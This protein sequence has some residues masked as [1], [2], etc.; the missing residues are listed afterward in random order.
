MTRRLHNFFAMVLMCFALSACSVPK[1][2]ET[3]IQIIDNHSLKLAPI[4][5]IIWDS[6][7]GAI[8]DLRGEGW[9][10][11]KGPNIRIEPDALRSRITQQDINTLY[12]AGI[13]VVRR[14][15]HYGGVRFA[16]DTAG[17]GISGELTGIL[18]RGSAFN[19]ELLVPHLKNAVLKEQDSPN[20]RNSFEF[21]RKVNED[22]A[23]FYEAR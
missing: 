17:L 20:T 15:S 9:Q 22:W 4:A 8:I 14:H 21:I 13:L 3:L 5:K 23:I 7:P 12:E 2:D 18:W 1:D 6:E 16:T 19:S 11:T 10:A